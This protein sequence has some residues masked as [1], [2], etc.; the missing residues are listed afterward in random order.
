[1]AA[2][3]GL[4]LPA[5]YN[6]ESLLKCLHPIRG[7]GKLAMRTLAQQT[8]H[9]IPQ[10]ERDVHG[11]SK[12]WPVLLRNWVVSNDTIVAGRHAKPAKRYCEWLKLGVVP[13]SLP[14]IRDFGE[15]G[16]STSGL[17]AV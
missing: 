17:T 8:M 7:C 13:K 16:A 4:S 9:K 11:L 6:A 3:G 15:T 12:P 10:K 5:G 2:T 14:T 1:M